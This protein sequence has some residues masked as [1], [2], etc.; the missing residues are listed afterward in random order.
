MKILYFVLMGL[1]ILVDLQDSQKRK[2]DA[3]TDNQTALR[4]QLAGCQADCHA[5][6]DML[7]TAL[8]DELVNN[9]MILRHRSTIP[10]DD[11]KEQCEAVA[12]NAL[13]ELYN[14]KRGKQ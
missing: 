7:Q 9:C 1:L 4:Q 10:L 14:R 5:E 3:L 8:A 11:R 13:N 12:I 2:C 6:I